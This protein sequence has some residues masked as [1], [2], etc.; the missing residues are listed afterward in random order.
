[1]LPDVG[2]IGALNIP[3]DNPMTEEGVA[4]G[5]LLFYEKLLSADGS[6][7]CGSCHKQEYAFT[8]GL[9]RA[10]GYRGDTL[11][12]NTMTLVNLAWQDEFF[13]D[14]R[15]KSLEELILV[16]VTDPREMGQD[17]AVLVTLL[18]NHEHYP[19]YFEQAFGSSRVTFLQVSRAIAQFLRSIVSSGIYVPAEVLSYMEVHGP[20]DDSASFG[21]TTQ[22]SIPAMYVRLAELCGACHTSSVYAGLVKNSNNYNSADSLMKVP[23]LV[24]VLYTEPYMHDGGL[25]SLQDVGAHYVNHID[26]L[27]HKNRKNNEAPP[28]YSMQP[29]DL[30]NLEHFFSFFTDTTILR[31]PAYANP[32]AQQGWTWPNSL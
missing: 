28:E 10:V 2:E 6:Y 12:R 1:V 18:Q 21:F 5:R 9:T 19:R 8:D 3:P 14:G 13:W 27:K 22:A 23:P 29:F 25:A 16:P 24:N 11:E 15:V 4:L 31:S 7:S 17:T 26:Q 32:Q 30:V 20:A